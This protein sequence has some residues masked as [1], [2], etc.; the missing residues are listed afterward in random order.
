[1][2]GTPAEFRYVIR[3][4]GYALPSFAY[5]ERGTQ[6]TGRDRYFRAEVFLREGGQDY[7]VMGYRREDLIADVLGQ[8][9][10][11]LN[12]LQAVERAG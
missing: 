1:M 6:P 9:E 10:R 8:Y 4:R 3:A 2:S 11:H 12:Y 7:D 5:F